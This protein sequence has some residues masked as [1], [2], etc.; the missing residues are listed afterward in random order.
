MIH[1]LACHHGTQVQI[2]A[3]IGIESFAAL[4][5]LELSVGLYLDTLVLMPSLLGPV[6]MSSEVLTPLFL[7]KSLMFLDI[8]SNYIHGEIPRNGFANLSKLVHLDTMQN[9]FSGS[10]PAEI[11]HLRN[12]QY[13]DMSSNQLTG[14]L[15]QEVDSLQ[16]LK[17]LTLESNL[18]Q[19]N[20]T[21]EIGNLSKLQQLSLRGNKFFGGIPSS[22]LNLKELQKLDLRENFLSMEIPNKFGELTNMTTLA[23][24]GNRLSGGNPFIN[25]EARQAGIT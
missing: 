24:S 21:D 5:N 7:V 12:L 14:N 19:E 23:L 4:L 13:L 3:N 6:L 25:A 8:S 18:L 2:V 20:I 17:V 11:F 10:I 22:I 1:L 9:N 16:N 15:S